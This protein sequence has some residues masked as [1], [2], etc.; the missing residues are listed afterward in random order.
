MFKI[1]Y[2]HWAIGLLFTISITQSYS[3]TNGH[4]SSINNLLHIKGYKPSVLGDIPAY[5]KSGN[6]TQAMILIPGLGFDAS[7]FTDFIEANK[8]KY[9]IY[10]ITIPGFGATMAP[11]MPDST[12]SYGDQTWS[13]GVI[14]GVLKLMIKE[15]IYKP[16]LVGHFTL[17]TQLALRI[18]LDYPDS[19]SGVIVLGGQAKFISVQDGKV[20]DYPLKSLI[21][22]TD[23]YTG[24]VMFKTKPEAD[25]DQ[26]N[27]LPEIYSLNK[28]IGKKL[29]NDVA[30]VPVP[31]MV[32]YL[33]EYM[34]SDIKAELLNIKCPVIILRPSFTKPILGAPINNYVKPQFI[35][36]WENL[37]DSNNLIQIENIS[38]SASFVW[39]D[40]KEK[41][42]STIDKFI[43]S[44]KH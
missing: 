23:L 37:T 44:I 43:T 20:L 32:R 27:Y 3:Q 30:A 13:K 19:I 41:T 38:N 34:A 40:Q 9:R 14:Q 22:A 6:G 21:K 5:T 24:P 28:K 39:K 12:V 7:V 18:A 16:V 25:W 26:G 33:C 31:V 11:P 1:F 2:K 15:K 35:D 42:Y 29:W 4:K 8:N 36:T 17:G 10:T